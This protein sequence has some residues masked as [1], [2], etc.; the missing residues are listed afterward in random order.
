MLAFANVNRPFLLETDASKLGLGAVLSQKQ[1]GSR[2]H[3]VAYASRFLTIHEHNYHLMKQE[4][5][6]LKWAIAEHFQEY[7]PGNFIVRTDNNPLT[8]NMTTTNL[9]TTQHWWVESLVRF[10]F[11]I[12][13]QKGWDNVAA[14]ALN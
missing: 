7:L 5:L 13:Y 12:K 9:D 11:G 1:T 10:T 3:L 2:Y 14:D 8:Y 6:A 4:F